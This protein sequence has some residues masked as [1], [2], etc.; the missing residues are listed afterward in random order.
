MQAKLDCYTKEG[1]IGALKEEKKYRVYK[2]K[3]NLLGEEHMQPIYFSAANIWLAQARLAKKEAFE[4]SEQTR[5]NA[6]KVAQAEKKLGLK[7]K[8]QQRHYRRQ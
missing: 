3:L 8:R 7:L 5:I 4:Q 1:L 6:K 2:K